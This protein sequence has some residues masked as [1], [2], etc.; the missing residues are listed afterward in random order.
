[1]LLVEGLSA[2]LIFYAHTQSA[3]TVVCAWIHTSLTSA[4][5]QP[6]CAA[7]RSDRPWTVAAERGRKGAGSDGLVPRTG[8][9]GKCPEKQR[10]LR[11]VVRTCTLVDW[12]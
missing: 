3:C 8:K 10:N 12:C 9:H 5:R 2:R 4:A 11:L 1:M 7:R 6:A